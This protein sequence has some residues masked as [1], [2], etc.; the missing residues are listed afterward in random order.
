MSW[1]FMT[2][3]T[4]LLVSSASSPSRVPSRFGSSPPTSP[5]TI[6]DDG[7]DDNLEEEAT[8]YTEDEI[9]IIQT[10]YD[11]EQNINFDPGRKN[12]KENDFAYAHRI[13]TYTERERERAE[14]GIVPKNLCDL[15]E[16]VCHFL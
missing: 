13:F 5:M 6:L 14:R 3:P 10:D 11:P 7:I 4:S 16:K 8:R 15:A 2:G 9:F 1:R 12:S